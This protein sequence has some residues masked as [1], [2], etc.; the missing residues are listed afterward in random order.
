MNPKLVKTLAAAFGLSLAACAGTSDDDN[1]QPQEPQDV[2]NQEPSRD[3][4]K[5][6][7][8]GSRVWVGTSIKGRYTNRE[9]NDLLSDQAKGTIDSNVQ[10]RLD[11]EEGR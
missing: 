5:L 2:A 4:K 6:T 9:A 7:P 1:N 11:A 8:V 10:Q 3:E